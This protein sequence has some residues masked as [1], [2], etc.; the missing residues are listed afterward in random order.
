MGIHSP[1]IHCAAWSKFSLFRV[2]VYSI[3]VVAL[4]HLFLHGATVLCR[5]IS[6][7]HQTDSSLTNQGDSCSLLVCQCGIS[8]ICLLVSAREFDMTCRPKYVLH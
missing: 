6:V 7:C 2:S 5:T 1:V 8:L 4:L 3:R